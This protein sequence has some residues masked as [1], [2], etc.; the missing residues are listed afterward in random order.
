MSCDIIFLTF[1]FF[2][3]IM[4]IVWCIYAFYDIRRMNKRHK[5]YHKKSMETLALMRE[6]YESQK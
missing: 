1:I 2:Y 4:A 5:E 6:K 3:C